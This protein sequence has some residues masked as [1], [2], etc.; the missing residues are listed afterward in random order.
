M[1][2]DIRGR[3]IAL[4]GL[5][6]AG[7]QEQSDLLEL[8]GE[9]PESVRVELDKLRKG[10][11]ARVKVLHGKYSRAQQ[12]YR[13]QLQATRHFA[14]CLSAEYHS[15]F[16]KLGEALVRECDTWMYFF[17]AAENAGWMNARAMRGANTDEKDAAAEVGRPDE[18]VQSEAVALWWK[19]TP[20][21]PRGNMYR[22]DAFRVWV[23]KR[24]IAGTKANR[25][26]RSIAPAF[27]ARI[28]E[29]LRKTPPN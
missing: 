2:S 27:F 28:C 10:K 26:R 6:I 25:I 29:R 13:T 14:E 16:T 19:E 7:V 21:R 8:G 9:Y 24:F 12:Y 22:L 15:A 17:D 3:A 18:I 5:E 1:D 23:D 20:E 4:Y 11:S